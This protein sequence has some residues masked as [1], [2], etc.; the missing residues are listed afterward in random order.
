[1]LESFEDIV[2]HRHEYARNWKER[3]GGKVLG[4]F[5]TYVPEEIIYA[6]GILPVRILGG[7]EPQDVSEPHILGMY[8]P[9][10]RDC[11]AEGLRGKYDY[12][13]GVVLARSCQHMLQ[14]F[15]SWTIHIPLSY[16]HFMG[17]PSLVSRPRARAFLRA[18]TA[19]FKRSLEEWTGKPI[20]NAD[21]DRAIETYNTNR[22]L[23]RQLYELRKADPP[24]L[25]GAEAAAVVL[26]SSLSDKAEHSRMLEDLL[27]MLPQRQ[28]GPHSGTRIM[29]VGSE[30]QSLDL[31][32]L[33]EAPGAN[34]VIDEMCTGSRYFWNE[35]IPQ[36]D[37]LSAIASRYLDRPRCP[38]R[39]VTERKRLEHILNLVRDFRVQGVLL[40]QQK[41]CTPHEFDIP[42]I[43]ELLKE[44]GIP[45]YSLELDVTLHQGAIRTRTEAFLE[46]LQ[47]ELV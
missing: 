22:R 3:T 38:I 26:A 25:S 35:V 11:L 34:I 24:L 18:E 33:I 45:T 27:E 17:M 36:E 5:C 7:L 40:L 16:S 28:D 8:C 20:G 44:N 19:D 14:A 15:H 21:L 10:C 1:L 47:L 29:V 46:M 13:D 30:N 9:F 31:F 42:A 2:E 12:L 39:D 23:L 32:R 4:F 6:A 41:F 37:R 43:N